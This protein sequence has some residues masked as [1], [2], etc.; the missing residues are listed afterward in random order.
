MLASSASLVV[1]IT[2]QEIHGSVSDGSATAVYKTD[3]VLQT[4]PEFPGGTSP[5]VRDGT[6][7]VFGS[8]TLVVG[9]SYLAFVSFNRGGDC[10]S[11]LFSYNAATQIA[12][13]VGSDAE[14]DA[15][16]LPLLGRIVVIPQTITL[17]D[18]QARM[19]PTGGVV[20]PADV[21]ESWC[22]GP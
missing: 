8:G 20:Y 7:M 9:M 13:L 12:T 5:I 10:L 11:A 4:L 16:R 6:P 22:P 1:I 2:V 18:V 21:G 3:T 14:P 19:Y 17:A 15:P